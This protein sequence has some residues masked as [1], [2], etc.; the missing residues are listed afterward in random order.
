MEHSPR[1]YGPSGRSETSRIRQT[2]HRHSGR[3]T[4]RSCHSP[5]DQCRSQTHQTQAGSWTT[6]ADRGEGTEHT[7]F[8]CQFGGSCDGIADQGG[9]KD[10]GGWD[11]GSCGEEEWGDSTEAGDFVAEEEAEEYDGDGELYE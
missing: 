2:G 4:A 6:G 8:Q 11:Q 7:L 3:S 5:G 10:F 1:R 9:E